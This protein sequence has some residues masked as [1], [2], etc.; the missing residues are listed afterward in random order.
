MAV[1]RTRHAISRNKH[2]P[3]KSISNKSS[4][5]MFKVVVHMSR[6]A[7]RRPPT[8]WADDLVKNA[9]TRWMREARNRSLWRHLGE[10]YVQQWTSIG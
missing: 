1:Q 5:N 6:K 3:S 10:T 9:G 4:V 2:S 7:Q 8:R